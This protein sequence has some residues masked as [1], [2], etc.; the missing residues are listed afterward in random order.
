MPAD[1]VLERGEPLLD[2]IQPTTPG[3]GGRLLGLVLAV[4]SRLRLTRAPLN[5]R[6]RRLGRWRLGTDAPSV[7]FL[8]LLVGVGQELGLELVAFLAQ[9]NDVNAPGL[10]EIELVQAR[11]HDGLVSPALGLGL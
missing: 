7:G 8:C 5:D 3:H 6:L 11:L 10:V 4:A 2:W 1:L 9:A